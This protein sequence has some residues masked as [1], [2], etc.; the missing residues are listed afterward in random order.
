M[1]ARLMRQND[2]SFV[3]A[4]FTMYL[5]K[6]KTR[7]GEGVFIESNHDTFLFVLS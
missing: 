3:G 2:F 1:I 7:R 4:L 5:G 6:G